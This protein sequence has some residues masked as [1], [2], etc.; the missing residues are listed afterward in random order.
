MITDTLLTLRKGNLIFSIN[1]YGKW[2]VFPNEAACLLYSLKMSAV[3]IAEGHIE[4]QAEYSSDCQP[5]RGK[6]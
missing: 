2:R 3:T 5:G 6:E 4:A 1:E